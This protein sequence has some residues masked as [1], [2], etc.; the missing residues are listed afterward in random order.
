M[1][2]L[3]TQTSTT[4]R[5]T[6]PS[7]V[8]LSQYGKL[9][10]ASVSLNRRVASMASTTPARAGHRG[11]Q[12]ALDE[13]LAQDEPPRRPVRQPDRGFPRTS[14]RAQKQEVG[15]VDAGD[16]EHDAD[17]GHQAR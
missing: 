6:R 10:L 3:A 5:N 2:T 17:R 4:N 14:E 16:E 8:Q 15:D 12:R 1:A 7:I 13:Q 9:M 11:E